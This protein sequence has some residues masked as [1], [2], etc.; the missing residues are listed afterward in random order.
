M[1][2]VDQ[3]GAGGAIRARIA[4]A[5]VGVVLTHLAAVPRHAVTP[6]VRVQVLAR[7]AVPTRIRLA[8]IRLLLAVDSLET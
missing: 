8:L 3:V 6:E 4:G 7:A 5:L 2:G 1:K